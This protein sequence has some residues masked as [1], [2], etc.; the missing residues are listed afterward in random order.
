MEQKL[1]HYLD[2][3][4]KFLPEQGT[5]E[6]KNAKRRSIGGTGLKNMM[7][8]NGKRDM[9][10]RLAG[11]DTSFNSLPMLNGIVFECLTQ[12][13]TG[14]ITGCKIYDAPGNI[15]SAE[16]IGKTY[17][18]DGFGIVY[19]LEN[20]VQVLR[21]VLFE[22]KT[23][24][25]RIP[26]QSVVYKTYIPQVKSG[27]ADIPMME[28]GLYSEA[29]TR[30]CP[31]E[32]LMNPSSINYN[33]DIHGDNMPYKNIL[34]DGFIVFYFKGDYSS[35]DDEEMDFISYL[36]DKINTE[37]DWGVD[38]YRGLFYKLLMLA[39][40]KKIEMFTSPCRT[41]PKNFDRVNWV[42]EQKRQVPKLNTD[43]SKCLNA[44]KKYVID[45]QYEY[46]GVVPWKMYEINIVTVDKEVG[47][48]KQYEKEIHETLEAAKKLNNIDDIVQ[49]EAEYNKVY[50]GIVDVEDIDDPT[51]PAA[52]LAAYI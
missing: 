51:D 22:F 26:V 8:E 20:G 25:S 37:F 18:P 50:L 30:I 36:T 42:K 33:V 15:P 6:W 1:N 14:I 10:C 49:R 16:V 45:Q 47:Y 2:E 28:L 4:W 5:K 24:W 27:L 3:L 52:M 23:M 48:T 11:L 19:M 31:W 41:Y 40:F 21:T 44:V 34:I 17:S 35:L 9:V 39:K 29:F 43:L 38:G 12:L 13:C 46:L 7:T 32:D